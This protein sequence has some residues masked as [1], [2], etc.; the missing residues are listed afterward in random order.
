MK[1]IYYGALDPIVRSALRRLPVSV[2]TEAVALQ[3]GYRFQPEPEWVVLRSGRKIWTNAVDHSQLLIR[4]LGT[5]EPKSLESMRTLLR[6]GATV[7]DVGANIGVFSIEAANIVGKDGKVISIEPFP[8]HA[9]AIRRSAEANDFVQITV[10]SCAVAD[11]FGAA[12]L[13]LPRGGNRGMFTI[14]KVS[15]SEHG[16]VPVSTIDEIVGD[17]QVDFI[18]MDIEGSEYRALLGA[19]RTLRRSK[20]PILIELNEAALQT[21]GSSSRKVKDVLMSHG[22][23]GRLVGSGRSIELDDQHVCDECIFA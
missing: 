20:P 8:F 1:R 14:G 17:K 5:F 23:S 2:R 16:D 4:Y 18:K 11:R 6:P 15:G 7:L 12:V 3:W 22:Y 10:V 21:C 9:D 13:S 19:E